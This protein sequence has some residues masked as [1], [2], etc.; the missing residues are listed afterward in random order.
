MNGTLSDRRTSPS[1]GVIP[2]GALPWAL[3]SLAAGGCG[4]GGSIA[5][6]FTSGT[7][8]ETARCSGNRGEFPLRQSDGLSVIII[9]TDQT[10]IVRANFTA[11]ACSDIVAGKEASVRGSNES[12]GIRA[13]EIELGS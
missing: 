12:A 8:S 6:H 4:D 2:A 13:T 9:V 5:V 10:T 3:L 7:V 1:L 11:G